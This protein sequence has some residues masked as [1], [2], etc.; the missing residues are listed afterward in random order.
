[1]ANQQA[2]EAGVRGVAEVGQAFRELEEVAAGPSQQTQF[3]RGAMAGYM[4][5]LGLGSSA[6]VTGARIAGAPDL[7]ELTAEVDAAMVQLE[8]QAMRTVPRDYTQGVHDAL[9]W[10]CGH[11]DSRP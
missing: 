8:D 7:A 11:T 5:A 1:M 6:P 2:F 9:A 3:T 10:V 4:W